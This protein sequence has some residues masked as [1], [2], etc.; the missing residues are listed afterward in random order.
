M[1]M[2]GTPKERE[3]NAKDLRKIYVHEFCL[4]S[5]WSRAWC[6]SGGG[7][8][9]R[10]CTFLHLAQLLVHEEHQL[11]QQVPPQHT[12]YPPLGVLF[13]RCASQVGGQYEGGSCGEKIEHHFRPQENDKTRVG[14]VFF[15]IWSRQ[16]NER[17]FPHSQ[18]GVP[19]SPRQSAPS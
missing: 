9:E 17:L 1:I 2:H 3:E 15:E 5:T 13:H 6:D 10:S 19:A 18:T 8:P 12:H 7:A 11:C 16:Q 14:S 4:C